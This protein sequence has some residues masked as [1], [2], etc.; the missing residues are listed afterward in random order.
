MKQALYVGD[1]HFA[2]A[3]ASLDT[4]P[5]GHVSIDVHYTGVCGTDLHVYHGDMDARVGTPAVIGHEMSGR[6]AEI[7]AAVEGWQV[8]DPVTVMPLDWCGTCPACQAGNWHVC[9][10]LT[11][12]GLDAPG[13]MQQRWTVPART[14]VRLPASL[15]LRDA[16]L[17][18]PT[19]VAVHDVRRA[20]VRPG[21][22]VLVV[23]AG[24]VGTLIALVTREMGGEVVVSEPDAFRR[25]VVEELGLRSI[26]PVGSDLASFVE[27]WTEGAGVP[28]AFEVSGS[29]A[30]LRSAVPVLGVRGRLCVVA[31]H[32]GEP[33]IDL[34]RFFW[35]ELTLVGARLYDREDFQTAVELVSGGVVPTDTL[36]SKVVPIAEAEQAFA[37]LEHGGSVMK[38]LVECQA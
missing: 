14:L 1:R 37:T 2:L 20:G 30:G 4:P 18:E 8:G 35:R 33:A 23:G 28:V 13:S 34:H 25:A 38:V 11:F 16:A 15:P 29:Q 17:V 3:E 12:I 6:I 22:K 5:A 27:E 26:D 19:A 36:I 24:P 9:Q 31:I 10:R 32:T 21:E 7:G